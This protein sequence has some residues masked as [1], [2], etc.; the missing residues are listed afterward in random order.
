[1]S[2]SVQP[3]VVCRCYLMPLQRRFSS[4][5]TPFSLW[6]R[7]LLLSPVWPRPPFVVQSLTEVQM[8]DNR[9]L[10][11]EKK[12]RASR[13]NQRPGKGIYSTNVGSLKSPLVGQ[14]L[15]RACLLRIKSEY[16][17]K[18]LDAWSY[19]SH[20]RLSNLTGMKDKD[21]DA[22]PARFMLKEAKST[23]SC[24]MNCLGRVQTR[25][26]L[27]SFDS[28]LCRKFEKFSLQKGSTSHIFKAATPLSAR[29]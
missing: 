1:M 21:K 22:L 2:T 29:A 18:L 8:G 19:W 20:W 5:P 12:T 14:M 16:N 25:R 26:F 9:V 13:M 27:L 11:H 6:S 23:I 4:Q 3:R 7:W 24:L 28:D 15:S 17:P 10:Q